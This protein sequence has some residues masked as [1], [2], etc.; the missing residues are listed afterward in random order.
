MKNVKYGA[1][2]ISPWLPPWRCLNLQYLTT[3]PT[4]TDCKNKKKNLTERRTKKPLEG[5]YFSQRF[6][7][8]RPTCLP[9]IGHAR[10]VRRSKGE[11]SGLLGTRRPNRAVSWLR[12]GFLVSPGIP[13]REMAER[14][15]STA[16]SRLGACLIPA[17]ASKWA[18][19]G[20]SLP[21]LP[22]PPCAA[23][24]LRSHH[25][26]AAGLRPSLALFSLRLR[27]CQVRPLNYR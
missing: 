18:A 26:P 8:R 9:L 6:E 21:L 23:A 14:L 20:R 22:S 2:H 12:F 15:S 5:Q 10:L 16:A 25:L 17:A 24:A 4:P 27:L 13:S 7:G 1:E 11:T 3:W 19:V